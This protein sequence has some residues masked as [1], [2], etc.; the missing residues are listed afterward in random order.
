MPDFC[1]VVE[2]E[3]FHFH[4]NEYDPRQSIIHCTLSSEEPGDNKGVT[5]GL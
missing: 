4:N 1:E 2:K 5:K 3:H